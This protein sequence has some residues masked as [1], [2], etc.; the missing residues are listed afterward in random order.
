MNG[1]ITMYNLK[2][3]VHFPDPVELTP[4][5]YGMKNIYSTNFSSSV[6]TRPLQSL[7]NILEQKSNSE[8]ED[9]RKRQEGI[10][11]QL[12]FL[13]EQM[14][15]LREEL[16][17]GAP[18]QKFPDEM[19]NNLSET[20]SQKDICV[21]PQWNGVAGE[22]VISVS[23][24]HPPYSLLALN[25]LWADVLR[26]NVV[27]HTHSSVVSLPPHLSCFSRLSLTNSPNVQAR[28]IWTSMGPDCELAVSPVSHSRIRGE[29]NVLR[30]L[31]RS[32]YGFSD[33]IDDVQL[34]HILDVCHRLAHS[35]TLRDKQMNVRALNAL[36]GRSRWLGG[37]NMSVADVAAWSVIKSTPGVELSQN[38]TRWN[39]L[40]AQA[41]D[42]GGA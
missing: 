19:N 12:N 17:K 41:F 6:V 7:P 26:L 14:L 31:H 21:K 11:K 29:I 28:L 2:P 42:I 5:M 9:L 15:S 37:D 25:R 34:D 39:T 4:T 3:L 38:M 32:I 30:F 13:K 36:L 33:P 18:C 23:P 20:I 10:L 27:C 16:S 22:I 8:V 40:C 24:E 1:P 35:H